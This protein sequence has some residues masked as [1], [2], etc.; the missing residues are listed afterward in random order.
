VDGV[1]VVI[2]RDNHYPN[3]VNFPEQ[4]WDWQNDE[5]TRSEND[6]K[7]NTIPFLYETTFPNA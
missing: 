5:L 7:E 1:K 2:T 6:D 4:G 3:E